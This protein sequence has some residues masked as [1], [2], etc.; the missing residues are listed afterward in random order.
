MGKAFL[1]GQ[2]CAAY[3]AD[4]K[5]RDGFI[6]KKCGHHSGCRKARHTYHCHRCHHVE[7]AT[8]GTL[9]HR[10]RFALRKAFH[11]VFEMSCNSKAM[12]SIQVGLRYGIGQPTAWTFMHKVRKA[13]QSSKQYLLS[14]LVHAN[15]FVVG[16]CQQAKPERS[17]QSAKNK[18]V[19]AVELSE[20]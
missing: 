12:S 14:K 13:M 17:Y 18:A 6:C 16:A 9:F 15:E 8:A 7:S 19:V 11:V 1:I 10:V 5:W 2:S 3:L 4:L 20:K